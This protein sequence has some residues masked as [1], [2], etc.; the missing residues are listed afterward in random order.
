MDAYFNDKGTW[1]RSDCLSAALGLPGLMAQKGG[2][3]YV[4]ALNGAGGKTSLIRRLAWEGMKQGLKVLVATTT[5]MAM[6]ARLGVFTSEAGDVKAMLDRESVA[7]AGRAATNGKIAFA[8]RALYEAVCPMADLV[9][10]EADG[11]KGLPLKVPGP[12]EPVV[13]D[14]ADMILCVSG[15]SA[16]GQPARD[17]C[18]RLEAAHA[19]MDRHGRRDYMDGGQWTIAPEDMA[20]LM[21]YGYLKPM[22]SRHRGARVIPVF[23]QADTRNL[24][25]LAGALFREMG[26]EHGI[27][28]GRLLEDEAAHIF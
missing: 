23:N 27:A 7:V 13:P 26:E 1:E 22:R 14:L 2:G 4:I 20:C 3:P 8:G 11:S 18:F 10:V 17:K 21:E 12:G 9:L 28:S 15:L 19:I 6:P 5:H 16:M 25:A 24:A